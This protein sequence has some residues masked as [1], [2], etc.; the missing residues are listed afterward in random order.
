MSAINYY[1]NKGY[2]PVNKVSVISGLNTI[3][4]W[5]PVTG[6]RVALTGITIASNPGGTIA[7][8]FDTTTGYKFA[9]FLVGGSDTISP[10]IGA[11]ES[12]VVSGRIF[13]VANPSGTDGWNVSLTGFEL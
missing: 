8:Y 4:V 1:L 6:K 13:A 3:S 5:T 11:I 12:T 9:E 10:N 7:F 2:T